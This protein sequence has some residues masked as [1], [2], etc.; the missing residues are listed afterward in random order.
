MLSNIP[1][2]DIFGLKKQIISKTLRYFGEK[3]KSF[4]EKKEIH[5]GLGPKNRKEVV[6]ELVITYTRSRNSETRKVM[7]KEV[8]NRFLRNKKVLTGIFFDTSVLIEPGILELD[9]LVKH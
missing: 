1:R 9:E 3:F 2:K 8:K 5:K 7:L 4:T 6:I